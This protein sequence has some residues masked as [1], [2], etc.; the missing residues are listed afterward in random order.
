M[1]ERK[2]Q[3][4][5]IKPVK[6]QKYDRLKTL[7]S[8]KAGEASDKTKT[9]ENPVKYDEECAALYHYFIY[10]QELGTLAELDIETLN[11][12]KKALEW[13]FSF[14][15]DRLINENNLADD[16]K[17][18]VLC[19]AGLV[20]IALAKNRKRFETLNHAII[21][22]PETKKELESVVVRIK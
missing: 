2:T 4:C 19:R 1:S 7:L 22:I 8:S 18:R 17:E 12:Y 21:E 15:N 10:E 5:G 3:I 14:L 13:R 9:E 20:E 6:L 11:S 16:K